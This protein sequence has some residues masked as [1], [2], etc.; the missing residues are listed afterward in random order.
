MPVGGVPHRRPSRSSVRRVV[1]CVSS[2]RRRPR[3]APTR[4]LGP[5]APSHPS[6]TSW[7][8]RF[9]GALIVDVLATAV[10]VC[11]G[12]ALVVFQYD[13]ND[14]VVLPGVDP[15]ARWLSILLVVAAV[16]PT[17]VRRLRP[18]TVLLVGLVPFVIA[19]LVKAPEFQVTSIAL[20]LQ[21][22]AVGRWAVDA[23]ARNLSRVLAVLALLAVLVRSIFEEWDAFVDGGFI[24]ADGY[25]L[26][27][28]V[29][30]V[31]SL[32]F[33]LASVL[34]GNSGRDR[35][36]REREL[37]A[38]TLELEAEREENARRAVVDE[39]IRIAR[40][41]HDVVAHHV[42]V[43]GV[44]AG[45]ARRVMASRPDAAADALEAVEDSSRQAVVE[46]HR[47]LGFLRD[48]SDPESGLDPTP[49]L[50]RL[51]ELVASVTAAGVQTTLEVVGDVRTVPGSVG[52]SG[53]RIV[54]EA[55]TNVL[56]HAHA[57]R[58]HVELVYGAT[59]LTVTVTDNGRGSAPSGGGSGAGGNGLVGMGERAALVGGSVQHGPNP[60]GGFRVV[61]DLPTDATPGRPPAP[62]RSASTADARAIGTGASTATVAG[63]SKEPA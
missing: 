37:A 28:I 39:R 25:L 24:P 31:F 44:Q 1:E 21:I 41:L 2:A 63:E 58:A 3:G 18:V 45:A 20:F 50:T 26:A 40:E 16:V 6:S 8:E 10:M 4:T 29:G 60:G 11:C 23:R 27:A 13:H 59:A 54:Q 17:A 48:E 15:P 5:V 51:D 56:R 49:G 22:Y 62:A 14:G 19:R 36:E 46:L 57:D 12:V 7:T 33:V 34:A 9:G 35:A 52:L 30:V 61:A 53:Y 32:V 43:M 55:L 42:S 38:R 47:L